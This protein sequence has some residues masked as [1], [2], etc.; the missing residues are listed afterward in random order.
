M[1]N[2]FNKHWSWG[3]FFTDNQLFRN[4]NSYKNAWCIGCLNHR[5][6]QLRQSDIV[7]AAVSGIS[8]GRADVDWEAQ[9]ASGYPT[10]FASEIVTDRYKFYVALIDCAPISGKP[11]QTMVPHLSKCVFIGPD[12][13]NRAVEE[14]SGKKN[15]R[16][17]PH[18]RMLG[19]SA[20]MPL[21]AIMTGS[22]YP[23]SL[24]ASAMPSGSPSPSPL[25]LSAPLVNLERLLKRARVSSFTSP[26]LSDGPQSPAGR[27]WN[28]PLQ[29][30]FGEDFCKLLI[31]T[32]SSWNTAH[33][34]QVRLFIEKWIPGKV[35]DKLKL[36]LKGRKAT[37][38]T[39]GWKNK[40]K[41]AI[42]A[43]MVSVDFEPYLMRTHD[44]SAQPKTGEALL[45]LVVEDIKWSEE[46][47]GLTIIAACSDDGGDARKM[48]RLLLALMPWLII[49]LCWAHQINLIV[50]DYLSLK[51]PFQDCVPKALISWVL[52]V[53]SQ[54]CARFR[55]LGVTP[56]SVVYHQVWTL[57]P[58]FKDYPLHD[59]KG[60]PGVD[61]P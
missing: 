20:S 54:A 40:V 2:N 43:T 50:G 12:V 10:F 15:R 24:S 11:G 53:D 41:Q 22:G 4:N 44:V 25:L 32:R 30:E 55:Q 39:D 23:T 14:I 34:P 1:S 18:A 46:M 56:L 27:V 3:Y 48:R 19:R 29:Q 36:K 6:D 21:P 51:L 49:V 42:V 37:F 8:S 59:K 38:Q 9:G 28:P 45:Q 13:R 7:N 31:A 61:D 5:K 26:Q 57:P 17:N 58:L 60:A 33:N 35:E 16:E 47:Y 52:V